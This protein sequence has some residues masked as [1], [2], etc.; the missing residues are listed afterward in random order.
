M[1]IT[2]MTHT[3]IHERLFFIHMIWS[4]IGCICHLDV[5][6]S[7]LKA[8]GTKHMALAPTITLKK[9]TKVQNSAGDQ[10]LDYFDD[11]LLNINEP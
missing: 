4:L 5:V 6:N 11:H 7:Y 3:R 9:C 2:I 10:Y 8:K 1:N